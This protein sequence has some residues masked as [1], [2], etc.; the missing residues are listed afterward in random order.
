[1]CLVDGHR[2]AS[3]QR[4]RS[5][6]LHR[7]LERT[8]A[9]GAH[10]RRARVHDLLRRYGVLV[11]AHGIV[12]EDEVGGPFKSVRDRAATCA[13]S[14]G[15]ERSS[16]TRA[17]IRAST[18]SMFVALSCASVNAAIRRPS[19]ATSSLSNTLSGQS[20]SSRFSAPSAAASSSRRDAGRTKA[21][22]AQRSSLTRK[23]AYRSTAARISNR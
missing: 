14:S 4:E 2:G 15:R 13:I 9:E 18:D 16:P 11:P 22:S 12:S 21:P 23:Q 8:R 1:M 7:L 6:V 20:S 10:E 5:Q 3:K 19:A 17:P